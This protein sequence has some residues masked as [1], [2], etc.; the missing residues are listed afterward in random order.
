MKKVLSFIILI[1][2]IFSCVSVLADYRDYV[3]VP[4]IMYHSIGYSD[5][6]YTITPETFEKH[7]A[8]IKENGF[9]PEIGRAH[10]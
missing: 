1:S 9:T 2:I 8:A 4:V 10:V 5:D 3:K 6:P 7:L